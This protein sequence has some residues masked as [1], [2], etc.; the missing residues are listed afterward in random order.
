MVFESPASS[1]NFIGQVA[2]EAPTLWLN[3]SGEEDDD[4]VP[5]VDLHW[6]LI[7]PDGFSVSRG[8]GNFQSDRLITQPSPIEQL[9]YWIYQIGGG[10]GQYGVVGQLQSFA[11]EFAAT[12]LYEAES[13]DSAE[14]AMDMARALNGQSSNRLLAAA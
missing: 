4:P 12:K 1:F 10:I 7:M 3:E 11:P 6:R 5:L 9:G 13:I 14:L 2:A 8:D